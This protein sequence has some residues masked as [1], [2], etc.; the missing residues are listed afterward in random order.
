MRHKGHCIACRTPTICT[1]CKPATCGTGKQLVMAVVYVC[2][3][4]LSVY[5]LFLA[6]CSNLGRCSNQS[7]EFGWSCASEWQSCRR[8]FPGVLW[9]RECGICDPF[10]K[11]FS[12]NYDL[13][14]YV[15]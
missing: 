11:S 14:V 9:C 5:S 1:W 10:S 8:G 4:V 6:S 15:V 7:R 12:Y 2:V 3:C 13:H